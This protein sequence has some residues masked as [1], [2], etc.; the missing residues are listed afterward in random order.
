[1]TTGQQMASQDKG[2][3]YGIESMT[4]DGNNIIEVYSKIKELRKKIIKKPQR[5]GG[6]LLSK[7]NI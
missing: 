6:I 3:G 7:C 5:Y 1:M 2:V 4:L